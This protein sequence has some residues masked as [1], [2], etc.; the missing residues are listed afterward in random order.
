V[1]AHLLASIESVWIGFH[2]I[3]LHARRSASRPSRSFG[4]GRLIKGEWTLPL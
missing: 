3:L 2:P 4:A 1:G